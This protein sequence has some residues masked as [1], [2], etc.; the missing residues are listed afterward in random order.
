MENVK[1]LTEPIQPI[2]EKKLTNQE[3][4]ELIAEN[5]NKQLGMLDDGINCPKCKN[6]G[7]IKQAI[8]EPMYNDYTTI[9][10]KCECQ[11]KREIIRK[12]ERSGLGEYTKKRFSDYV[13][14]EPW[15]VGMKQVAENYCKSDTSQWLVFLG[16]SGSGKTLLA[17]IVTNYLLI[18]KEKTVLY[19]TWTDFISKLKRDMMADNT[20]SVSDYLNEVKNVEVLYIDELLK[21]FTE[22]DLKYI[23]EIINYRYTNNLQTIITSERTTNE[24]V[25]IDEATFSR[26]IEKADDYLA[27]INRDRKK[28]YR[29]KKVKE[30]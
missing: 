23:I 22:T 6:K 27:L 25:D 21:R 3:Y 28:N 19:L 12:A 4:Q 10:L 7:F 5:Y 30:L 29:L 16:Q 8:Y 14:I 13:A 15:Q 9:T 1:E 18:K 17:S 26:V 24:L 2:R 20:Q 11:K